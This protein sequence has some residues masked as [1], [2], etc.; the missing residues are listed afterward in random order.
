MFMR[1]IDSRKRIVD[2]FHNRLLFSL[3]C[4]C[5]IFAGS[6]FLNVRISCFSLLIA[7]EDSLGFGQLQGQRKT[8]EDDTLD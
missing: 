6:R 4:S 8:F 5:H 2:Y 3:Q 7:S 1:L